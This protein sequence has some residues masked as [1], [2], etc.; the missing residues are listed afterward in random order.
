MADIQENA[1]VITLFFGKSK[2]KRGRLLSTI[3]GILSWWL[4][5]LNY[6]WMNLFVKLLTDV[7]NG[8]WI[9]Y[10]TVFTLNLGRM[11]TEMKYSRKIC[12]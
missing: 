1:L 4:C 11:T 9:N 10:F 2:Q 5:W 8:L 7:I 12:S 6:Y 3:V